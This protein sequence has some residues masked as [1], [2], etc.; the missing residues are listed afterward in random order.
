EALD[1]LGGAVPDFGESGRIGVVEQH[2]V[3][4]R[5]VPVEQVDH[6]APDPRLVDVVGDPCD[7]LVDDARQRHTHGPV[8]SDLPDHPADRV[9]DGLRRGGPGRGADV[10]VADQHAPV[11][12]DHT[13][14]DPGA[15]D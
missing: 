4:I 15:P 8:P 5:Q 2:H 13:D 12:V 14:L 7:A 1:A 6:V 3:V 10:T 11:E 9:R